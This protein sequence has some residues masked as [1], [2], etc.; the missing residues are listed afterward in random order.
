MLCTS[1]PFAT[2]CAKMISGCAKMFRDVPSCSGDVPG[3]LFH[4]QMIPLQ[5]TENV[6]FIHV[7]FKIAGQ[8]VQI[9]LCDSKAAVSEDLLEGY[10]GATH[11]D[12]FLCKGV[13]EPMNARFIQ[14]TQVAVV[15][16]G[17]VTA[18]SG[19]LFTVGRAEEPVIGGAATIFQILTKNLYYIFVQWNNQGLAVFRDVYI[20][21]VV[22][23]V[24]VLDSD[25]HQTILTDT[26]REQKANNS[27]TAIGGK[28]TAMN[29][30]LLQELPQFGIGVCFDW[31]AV[32]FW[33]VN[34]KTG[35]IFTLHKEAHQNLQIPCVCTHGYFVQIR[36]IPQFN[37]KIG[38]G[39]FR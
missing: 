29:I 18:A 23:E 19:E 26:S 6:D 37:N 8:D 11:C 22:I 16:N 13:T 1:S 9:V 30:R 10:D 32:S 2:S 35:E 27:P 33:N 4:T 21:N 39:L 15:P 38:H 3:C 28:V 34:F 36:I 12:P 20:D 31:V 14:S 24:H 17:V 7:P 5:A 25:I